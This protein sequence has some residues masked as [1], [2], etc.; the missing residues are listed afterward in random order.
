MTPI[1]RFGAVDFVL[2]LY[3]VLLA[4]GVRAGY[5][6]LVRRQRPQFR[7][8]HRSGSG[9]RTRPGRPRPQ[10]QGQQLLRQRRPAVRRPGGNGPR[11]ARLP[12]GAGDARLVRTDGGPVRFHRPL[13]SVRSR[14]PDGGPLLPVRPAG[15][16]QPGRRRAG[17]DAVRPA[18]VLGGG[19]G[20]DQRR[21]AGQLPRRPGAV[22][23]GA[24]RPDRRAVRQPAL[25]PQPG[26]HGP[27]AGGAT[28]VRLH[29]PRLV[30]AAEPAAAERLARRPAGVPRLRHRRRPLDHPQ[31]AGLRRTDADRRFRLSASVDGQQSQGGRRPRGRR[32]RAAA[33]EGPGVEGDQKA[34]G[35]LRPPRPGRVGRHAPRPAGRAATLAG[36]PASPSTSAGGSWGRSI[37]WWT[38]PRSRRRPRRWIMS[39]RALR[40]S[41]E[42]WNPIRRSR[43]PS[44]SRC[45]NWRLPVTE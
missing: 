44:R 45:R 23:R 29:W 39:P 31:L 17:R 2:F 9:R 36:N 10:R 27:G 7:I 19:R 20:R 4:G 34:A 42:A 3:V 28:A 14:R 38:W 18:S 12:L 21:H 37:A 30:P 32:G 5:L 6:A 26:G 13:D 16:P 11:L 41:E 35:A 43:H 22:H 25:R 1:R 24:G 40:R 33:G 8:A 15:L